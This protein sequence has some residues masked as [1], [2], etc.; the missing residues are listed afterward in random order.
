MLRVTVFYLKSRSRRRL[1]L[2]RSSM[3]G[4][5]Y[6]IKHSTDNTVS[7]PY[8][9]I[10]MVRVLPFIAALLTLGITAGAR[11]PSNLDGELKLLPVSDGKEDSRIV[12]KS[13]GLRKLCT[14]F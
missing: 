11:L 9:A 1:R 5:H 10:K 3:H 7:K 6:S 12:V 4:P 14:Y 13:S 2:P 8:D